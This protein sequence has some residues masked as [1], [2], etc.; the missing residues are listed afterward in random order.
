MKGLPREFSGPEAKKGLLQRHR[1]LLRGLSIRMGL[2][3][4]VG[5]AL[6]AAATVILSLPVILLFCYA[7]HLGRW[8]LVLLLLYFAALIT[9]HVAIVLPREMDRLRYQMGDEAFFL[10]YPK[11]RKKEQRRRARALRRTQRRRGPADKR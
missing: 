2:P 4:A 11:E 8:W 6:G 10:V 5:L 7:D 1:E 9:V 3:P